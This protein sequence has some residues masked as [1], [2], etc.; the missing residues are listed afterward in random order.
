MELGNF[1]KLRTPSEKGNEWRDAFIRLSKGHKEIEYGFCSPSDIRNNVAPTTEAI[2]VEF[3]VSVEEGLRHESAM[4]S[5]VGFE[6][7]PFAFTVVYKEG[8]SKKASE[9][10]LEISTQSE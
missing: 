1:V 4:K 10:V 6:K 2:S 8:D 5:G 3:L 9:I 7:T